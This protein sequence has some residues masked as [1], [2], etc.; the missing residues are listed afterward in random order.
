MSSHKDDKEEGVELKDGFLENVVNLY[1]N[2][3]KTHPKIF[4]IKGRK[5]DKAESEEVSWGSRWGP[6][7]VQGWT[8]ARCH[9]GTQV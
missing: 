8:A 4:Y 2:E 7:A 9:L 5:Q 3:V 6:C 1:L